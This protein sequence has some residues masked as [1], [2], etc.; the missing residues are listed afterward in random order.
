MATVC[1]GAALTRLLAEL[2]P[3]EVYNLGAQSHVAVSFDTPGYTADVVAMGT[4]RLLEAIRA[5]GLIVHNRFYQAGSS[6]MFGKV[7]ETPQRETTPFHPRS[8]Y[9]AL[10]VTRLSRPEPT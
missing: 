4:L 10:R 2:R 8:P 7:A 1:D 9:G 6:E 5:C 3:H